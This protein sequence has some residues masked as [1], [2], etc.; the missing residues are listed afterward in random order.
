MK[1]LFIIVSAISSV[2]GGEA[3]AQHIFGA[4]GPDEITG[5]CSIL[6]AFAIGAAYTIL[7][8]IPEKI[9]VT[10]P[11][12]KELEENILQD[13]VPGWEEERQARLFMSNFE[14]WG[15]EIEGR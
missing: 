5:A 7:G 3:M 1:K 8:G 6:I 15:R 14:A 12:E 4:T 10:A 11:S 9:A 2:C 13:P